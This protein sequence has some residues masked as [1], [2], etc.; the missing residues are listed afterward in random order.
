MG[1]P[2]LTEEPLSAIDW[3]SESVATPIALTP[4]NSDITNS[5]AIESITIEPLDAPKPDAVG[6]LSPAVT[7]LPKELWGTGQSSDIA[8][9][10]RNSP[11]RTLPALAALRRQLLLA[12]TAPP[13]NGDGAVLLARIDK[14]LD[15]GALED[16]NGLLELSGASTPELFRRWFDVSLLMGTEDRACNLLRE[17]GAIAPS[18]QTRIF[19]LARNGD[20][21]A[22]ALTLNSAE[23][24]GLIS[25]DD[26]ALISRFLDPELFEGEPALPAPDRPT[27]LMF[28]MFEA[29]GEPLPTATLP[30]AFAHAD[31]RAV[32]GWK[33]RIEAGERLAQ[34]GAIRDN[35]LLGI[36]SERLPAASGGVWE[37]VD[38]IQKFE[39]ALQAKDPFAL[40]ETLPLLWQEVKAAGL[41][42]SFAR[43]F[44]DPLM[45]V[46]LSGDA[47]QIA[48]H[49]SLLSNSYETHAQAFEAVTPE[50]RFLKALAQGIP[51]TVTAPNSN[52]LAVRDGFD[53]GE[54]PASE[55]ALLDDGRLGELLLQVIEKMTL[56][57]G[58]DTQAVSSSLRVLRAVGLED[59]ARQAG[60][61][62]L[63]MNHLG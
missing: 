45:E 16:A 47:A 39:L 34:V 9:L 36:Y 50:D 27:P 17:N 43:L 10:V 19:C 51:Q 32:S 38:A 48:F 2:G 58:G 13:A 37:R 22:A 35:Q 28:R 42:R 3:L 55:Q 49:I 33:A 20:W 59:T 52:A 26:Y 54:L 15:L 18:Y 11:V 62:F 5:A 23:I 1:Q 31:L 57:A 41:E 6:L 63:L 46:E 25:G 4:D 56:G 61:Q 7:G 30:R 40:S 12:E 8:R 29:I 21:N 24:L 44:A 60:L 14:L 53:G